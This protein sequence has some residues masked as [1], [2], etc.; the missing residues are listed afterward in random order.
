MSNNIQRS[1]GVPTGYPGLVAG[2]GYKGITEELDKAVSRAAE[3]LRDAYGMDITIRFNSDRRY[4]GAWLMTS[5]EDKIGSNSDIGLNVQW[6]DVSYYREQAAKFKARY[7]WEDETDEMLSQDGF[8]PTNP[9]SHYLRFISF[10]GTAALK[11]PATANSMTDDPQRRYA[12]NRHSSLD[13]ALAFVQ[14]HGQVPGCDQTIGHP[15]F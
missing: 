1:T 10:I 13:E 12:S 9:P 6:V 3:M 11:D 15:K 4:G 7:G 14:E 5:A 2:G 8:D